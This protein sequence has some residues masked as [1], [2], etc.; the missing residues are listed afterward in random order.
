MSR[1]TLLLGGARKFARRFLHFKGAMKESPMRKRQFLYSQTKIR[2]PC[3][4]AEI[5]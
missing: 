3:R 5:A 2:S 4:R 1:L